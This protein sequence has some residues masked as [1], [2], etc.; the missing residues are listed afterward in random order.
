MADALRLSRDASAVDAE[1]WEQLEDH[2]LRLNGL[3][4]KIVENAT[5]ADAAAAELSEQLNHLKE[6][7]FVLEQRN[8]ELQSEVKRLEESSLRFRL[9]RVLNQ[10]MFWT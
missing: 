1:Q 2:R 5:L 3:D 8:A 7:I 10:K 4:A 9:K 6:L